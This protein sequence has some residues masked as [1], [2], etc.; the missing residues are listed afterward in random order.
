MSQNLHFGYK[1]FTSKKDIVS[2]KDLVDIYI[3]LK[4]F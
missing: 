4:F 3:D 2:P 1:D